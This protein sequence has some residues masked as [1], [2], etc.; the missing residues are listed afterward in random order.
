MKA[1]LTGSPLTSVISSGL[2]LCQT[3]PSHPPHSAS[4]HPTAIEPSA[5]T[6]SMRLLASVPSER[7]ND[8]V[9][10]TNRSGVGVP[11]ERLVVGAGVVGNAEH[12]T[13]VADCDVPVGVGAAAADRLHA[14]PAVLGVPAV[15][16]SRCR[17]LTSNRL[18]EM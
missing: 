8:E 5:D 16:A 18:L 13:V 6:W 12:R 9:Y 2:P 15:G 11:A 17:S 4:C 14:D 7:L 10:S 1:S 3:V